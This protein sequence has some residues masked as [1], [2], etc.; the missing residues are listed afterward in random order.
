MDRPEWITVAPDNSAIYCTLTNNS[1]REVTDAANPRVEN[2]HGHIIKWSEEGNSPLATKF[3]WEIFVLAGDPDLQSGGS[4][5]VGNIEGD[6]YSS[7]DGLRI[8]P[9]GRLWV[10][11]RKST[12][13]NSVTNAHLVCRLLLEKKKTKKQRDN[14]NE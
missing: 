3:T 2:R 1:G 10:Q 12:R 13:L 11:D 4:N 7:P 14:N 6:T 8:D 5:L 9:Q